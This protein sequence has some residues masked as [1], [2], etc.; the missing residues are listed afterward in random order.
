MKLTT[1]VAVSLLLLSGAA[2]AYL[3]N[4]PS[5][6]VAALADAVTADTANSRAAKFNPAG[7]GF[8]RD[9]EVEVSHLQWAFD[10]A[11]ENV[12]AAYPFRFG[13]LGFSAVMF[14]SYFDRN[15][16]L[17]QQGQKQEKLGNSDLF[18]SLGY[19]R[20]IL[21]NRLSAGL[22]VNYVLHTLLGQNA[23][24]YSFSLGVLYKR[25]ILPASLRLP[26]RQ[27]LNREEDFRAGFSATGI[28]SSDKSSPMLFRAGAAFLPIP[29]VKLLVDAKYALA[30]GYYGEFDL[31][32]GL[33]LNYG[34]G[35][36]K[37][38]VRTGYSVAKK[39]L[40][41]GAG[42]QMSVGDNAYRL[43]YTYD[44]ISDPVV[45]GDL[46]HNNWFSL[47]VSRNPV[48]L[49]LITGRGFGLPPELLDLRDLVV[50]AGKKGAGEERR[51]SR[52]VYKVRVADISADDQYL[53]SK[54]YNKELVSCLADA[55]ASFS[56]IS[57]VSADA[58]ADILLTGTLSREGEL[59]LCRMAE[60]DGRSGSVIAQN[61]FEKSVTY[62]GGEVDYQT[63]DIM[64]RKE[65]DKVVIVPRQKGTEQDKDLEKVREAASEAARW[66]SETVEGLMSSEYLVQANSSNVD[67]YVD[68]DFKGRTG[69]DRKC[70]ITVR[71]GDHTLVFAKENTPKKEMRVSVQPGRRETITVA[72]GEGVFYADVDFRVF[73]EPLR[74][75]LDGKDLGQT[76]VLAKK[77]QNGKHT[78]EYADRNGRKSR[79]EIEIAVEGTYRITSVNR[80]AETFKAIDRDLWNVVG[81]EKGIAVSAW[82]RRL[83]VKGAASDAAW[84]PSGLVSRPF[85]S[86]R[87]QLETD[88]RVRGDDAF[89]VIA[90][91]D[92]KGEG[93]GIGIDRKYIQFFELGKG[94]RNLVP[95]LDFKDKAAEH[96]LKLSYA[97][98]SLQAEVDDL[99]LGERTKKLTG[100]VRVVLLSDSERAG[101]AVE[102]ELRNLN[103]RNELK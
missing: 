91:V 81:R 6:S 41:L 83:Q 77:V 92:E 100:N 35:F 58:D 31:V 61:S 4:G 21:K 20:Q 51:V 94:S 29:W 53:R 12:A 103:I 79:Q 101:G 18:F 42:F 65:G 56:N 3:D 69:A 52:D 17:Y 89:A 45:A 74:V 40:K 88:W 68:G 63:L 25:D 26:G 28:F 70:R 59:M 37:M 43:D 82:N 78:V 38:F 96:H 71:K 85:R 5:A 32:S 1:I 11:Y 14:H 99:N 97:G 87:L 49:K 95:G 60:K 62:E 47:V 33:E 80:Y 9:Y 8:L 57:L 19:G 55:F 76:P 93:I 54:S 67:V 102:M 2:L 39:E 7:L 15:N 50:V 84:D 36:S 44:L 90:L 46:G 16:Y 98:G 66:V 24:S 72:M 64:V 23:G 30:P 73:G 22:G 34:I 10:T 75:V 48:L 27:D 86:D 13:G